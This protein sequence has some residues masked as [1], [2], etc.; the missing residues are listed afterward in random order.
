[1][2]PFM[3]LLK[4]AGPDCNL[5]CQYCFYRA[6]D[7]LWPGTS[8]HRM[9]V[10]VLERVISS[11]LA[12][13]LPEHVFCWQGGEPTLMGIDFFRR[14]TEFQER[15][16]RPGTVVGNALQTNGTLVTDALAAHFAR[17]RFLVGC[18]LDGPPD[19][20]DLYRRTGGNGQ[21]GRPTHADTLRG[22]ETLQ[23]Y[24]VAVNALVLVS[25][26]NVRH[27]RRVYEHLVGLGLLHQQ[28]IPC[29]ERGPDGQL[30]PFSIAGA[31]WGEFLCELFDAWRPTGVGRIAIRDFEAVLEQE[32]TGETGLCR[33]GQ[34]CRGHFVVEH[35]GSIYPCD[36]FVDV[37]HRLGN[38]MRAGWQE[39]LDHERRRAFAASKA[40]WSAECGQCA[41]L[42]WCGGDCLKFRG[43]GGDPATRSLLCEGWRRF[44]GHAGG[45]LREMADAIRS[46]RRTGQ[47][48]SAR[49]REQA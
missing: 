36:F 47:P 9:S 37:E 35:D 1:M 45:G 10:E 25:Q 32:V 2:R 22:I 39:L 31:E 48:P 19:Q 7:R 15:H 24:G 30:Q 41:Y 42:R 43:P 28:Y 14:V 23:R 38:I 34:R 8:R 11:Y 6:R 44:F 17:Y 29:V 26:A 16:G 13:D 18:S 46:A 27:A 21:S 49:R 12:L 33:P 3:L 5:S 20:H 4:P 40:A